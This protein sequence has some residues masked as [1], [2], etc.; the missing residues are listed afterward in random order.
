MNFYT[1]VHLYRNEILLRGYEN[2]SRIKRSIEYQPYLFEPNKVY[3]AKGVD[4][5]FRT[6]KGQKVYK[7]EFDNIYEARDYIKKFEGIPGKPIFGMTTFQYAFINDNYPN[8]IDYDPKAISVVT[9]DIETSTEGGFPDITTANR[10]V[11]AITV[12]KNGQSLVLGMHP[13]KVSSDS[14]KYF[15]CK[16]E[17]DL[18]TKF[19]AIWQSEQYAPDVLTGWNVEFFDIPYLVNRIRRIMGESAAKRLSPWGILE[20]R[21]LEIMGRENTV[22]VPVGITIIDYMQAYKKFSFSQQE[23]FKLDHIAFIELGERKLDYSEYESMHD[24]YVKDFQK[25]IDYNIRDVEL[26]DKLEDKL[27]FLEQIFAIAYDGKVNLIDAFTSVRMWD[28]I[29]HNYLL[30]KGIVVPIT[31]KQDK[32]GQIVGAY[33]KDPQVGRHDWVV[34]FDLNSLYPHLIMQYN[35]SPE[36]IV[37]Q[38]PGTSIESILDGA[39]NDE[40]IRSSMERDNVAVAASG[41]KFSRDQQGFLPALMFNM[42]NDRVKY[43]KQM[44][45]A[46]QQYEKTPTYELEK[47]IARCHN[48]QLAK[49]IQLNSAYGALSNVYFRWFDT[50]LAESITM[51]GQ[52]SI[53]WME[54]RINQYLNK[55]LKTNDMDYVIA[56][57]TDSMYLNLAEFVR[58]TAGDKTVEETVTYLDKVCEQVFEPFI[59]KSYQQLADYVNAF[60]QKMKMKREAI[61]NKGIWTAKKRYI[62]NVY[63]N[64]GVQYAEPKLKLSGIEAV[65]SS[66]PSACR[67]NI[68]QALKVIMSGTESDLQSFIE[69]F[70]N[71]FKTLPFED[72]A[73]PRSVRGLK[74]YADNSTIFRKSTP[75]H[76]RGALIYNHILKNKGLTERLQEIGEGEKIKFCYLLLPNSAQSNIISAPGTLPKE[77]ELAKYIDYNKQFEKSFLEPL[78]TILDAIGWQSEKRSTLDAFF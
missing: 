21:K 77:F 71:E 24:F 56:C 36:T 69:K 68:K 64:E 14:V 48:M 33:V 3:E 73:F 43:K 19:L 49:K 2:G 53:R 57:D 62:L 40:D 54:R 41:F 16:D 1:N 12:R 60:D 26:V 67:D 9:L 76:V 37:G 27:K 42:Y 75:I 34:S 7:R 78:T 38:L 28:I 5:P 10:M 70:R 31:D 61:A 63:N 35:I 65:R 32:D 51:S 50:N 18:L 25:Y 20:E 45:A 72:I 11:T 39:L 6:L 13:Y 74:E 46:K 30:K 47:E 52:L 59:D 8:D 22:Y 55:V 4:T 23:S 15:Q 58:Q 44:I 17:T 66:T 29:I